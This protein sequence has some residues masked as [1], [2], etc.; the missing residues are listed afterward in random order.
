VPVYE[1]EVTVC[2]QIVRDSNANALDE[3]LVSMTV[4]ASQ[5]SKSA[6]MTTGK[7]LEILIDS[8]RS[9]CLVTQQQRCATI[10]PT[11]SWK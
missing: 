4:N 6:V 8:T 9:L 5:R 10:Y 7:Y 2:P 11:S 1:L 3:A